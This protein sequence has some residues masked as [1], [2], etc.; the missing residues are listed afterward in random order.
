MRFNRSEYSRFVQRL[1]RTAEKNPVLWLP[2]IILLAVIVGFGEL[3]ET[4]KI[5]FSRPE[6][7]T[8]GGKSSAAECK[9]YQKPF[10]FR[11]AAM[12]LACAFGFMFM[13]DLGLIAYADEFNDDPSYTDWQNNIS[14]TGS[15][16]FGNMLAD[17][18]N[19]KSNEQ[20]A[21]AGYNVFSVEMQGN[22]AVVDFETLCDSTIVVGIYDDFGFQLI[23]TGS[24]QV[25]A[26]EN[27]ATVELD[28]SK[29]PQY[30]YIKAYLINT[31]T[32]RPLCTV[33]EC[34]TYTQEMQE[35]LSKTV[36]DFDNNLVLNLDDDITN[37][38]AVFDEDTVFIKENNGINIVSS[39][40][41]ENLIYVIDNADDTVKSLKNGDIF[42]QEYGNDS[43]LIVKVNS[44]TIDSDRVTIYGDKTELEEVFDYFRVEA[45]TNGEE[46][47]L[48]PNSCGE[49]VTYL[50][51]E[52]SGGEFASYSARAGLEDSVEKTHKVSLG[53]EHIKGTLSIGS[54]ATYKAYYDAHLFAKD[55]A[56]FELQVKNTMGIK[57]T[58]TEKSEA[59][60]EIGKIKIFDTGIVNITVSAKIKITVEATISVSGTLTQTSGFKADSDS[61]VQ[62]LSVPL[63]FEPDPSAK[64][65]IVG[66]IK[67]E[68]TVEISAN[69]EVFKIK[70]F[71][72]AL[73]LKPYIEIVFKP[74]SNI[75]SDD[76]RQH[77]C[78]LCISGETHGGITLSFK[79]EVLNFIKW[80]PL[81]VT[82]DIKLFEF[83]WSIISDNPGFGMGNCPNIAYRVTTQV[84]D[85]NRVP[86]SGASVT[87][88]GKEYKTDENGKIKCYLKKGGYTVNVRKDGYEPRSK[89]IKVFFGEKDIAVIICSAN[90]S[91]NVVK[92][93]GGT[94]IKLPNGLM[95]I[96]DGFEDL[97]NGGS[98]DIELIDPNPIDPDPVDPDPTPTE[99]DFTYTISN[100]EVTITG[101]KGTDTEVVIPDTIEGLP[102]TS[103]GD[104]AFR[105]CT[106]LTSIIIPN[107]VTSIGGSAFY[108]CTS[109]TIINIPNSVTSIRYSAFKDCTSLTSIT[110]PDSVTSIGFSAFKGCTSLINIKLPNKITSI[111]RYA[112]E[113]CTNLTSIT[114]PNS[115]TSIGSY[116][117]CDC[118][119][120][121]S[122]TIPDSVTYLAMLAFCNCTSLTSIKLSRAC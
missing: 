63:K 48:D 44:I 46:S 27:Q 1:D 8:S 23:T 100:G 66:K 71:K 25:T 5:A 9:A 89:N 119:S 38:F 69:I 106:S 56:Y 12:S 65:E 109:L 110:I 97:I 75:I 35:F 2:C 32:M 24:A 82:Y 30:F 92:L 85:E 59:P 98:G 54:K 36:N 79:I 49:G 83:Y 122:I 111:G 94:F 53:S 72:A 14:V 13:S 77:T 61:D 93:P 58:G 57:V 40:D 22:T 96:I 68:L 86:L 117:F 105:D 21:N 51:D 87:V 3:R 19:S 60:F 17:E 116:A 76:K 55:H 90:P 118:K 108:G 81:N 62:D 121:T 11:A 31:E 112:F 99:S 52:Y 34:P 4:V 26:D 103:I 114:I 84:L 107:S 115:V 73:S 33:Y 88:D 101:Y 67:F 45:K 104:E 74:H 37:N 91:D 39:V 120:L 50:G 16:P 47:S 28:S 41:E 7:H 18:F 95:E 6:R 20:E 64:T 29:I 113:D 10:L 42:S 15:D 80:E 70:L 102:V 78:T 43:M